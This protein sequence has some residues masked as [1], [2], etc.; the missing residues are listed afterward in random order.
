LFNH[1]SLTIQGIGNIAK[2]TEEEVKRHGVSDENFHGVRGKGG[3]FECISG[4]CLIFRDM[5]PKFMA[6][7]LLLLCLVVVC[8]GKEVSVYVVYQC[9]TQHELVH[10][11]SLCILLY[12]LSST[13]LVTSPSTT[14]HRSMMLS[15]TFVQ[16]V[17]LFQQMILTFKVLTFHIN[18]KSANKT[19][20]P[21]K[22]ITEHV[23]P[24]RM[25]DIAEG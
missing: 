3:I 25:A 2:E 4:S 7:M 1:L 5:V 10:H 11:D 14:N 15:T 16:K 8:Q 20:T 6:K 23:C 19:L 12:R 9:Q 17:P 24:E 13:R 18:S 22:V 21:R